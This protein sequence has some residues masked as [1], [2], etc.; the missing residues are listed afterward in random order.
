MVFHPFLI[1]PNGKGKPTSVFAARN[2]SFNF[3]NKA[4]SNVHAKPPCIGN[5]SRSTS[6]LDVTPS[7][8][9]LSTPSFS[10]VIGGSLSASSI[11]EITPLF[12]EM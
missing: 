12:Y 8:H 9:E 1:I 7:V 10:D 5:N 3:V 2:E 6:I 11:L 4:D